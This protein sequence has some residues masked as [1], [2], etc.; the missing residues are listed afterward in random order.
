MPLSSGPHAHAQQRHGHDHQHRG[1]VESAD[2]RQQPAQRHQHRI[3]Q[4][5]DRAHQRVAKVRARPLQQQPQQDGQ[6]HQAT[7]AYRSGR[8]VRPCCGHS[9]KEF[10]QTSAGSARGPLSAASSAP[11][12]VAAA[13]RRRDQFIEAAGGS[14][15]PARPR[16]CRPWLVTAARC[17]ASA[18][19]AL[20]H[21]A[22]PAQCLRGQHF[23][24][25]RGPA[26]APR[27]RPP[28]VRPAEK[29]RRARCPKA[30]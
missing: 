28:D 21:R 14:A 12:L 26:P 15:P 17:A 4:L 18:G 16:W 7:A 25:R 24:G 8:A 5:H 27:P 20:P 29:S 22:S 13:M 11:R 19:G 2:G 6:L 30:R 10:S 3:G 9:L 1:G 23:R